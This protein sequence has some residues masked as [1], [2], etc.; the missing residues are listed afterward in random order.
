MRRA[1]PEYQGDLAGFCG[2]LRAYL[3]WSQ[4]DLGAYFKL[5]HTAITRYEREQTKPQVGYLASLIQLVWQERPR[6]STHQAELTQAYLLAQLNQAINH[7]YMEKDEP[8]FESWAELCAIGEAYR[9]KRLQKATKTP[10]VDYQHG[11]DSSTITGILRQ[12]QESVDDPQ[13]L[14]RTLLTIEQQ[15]QDSLLWMSRTQRHLLEVVPDEPILVDDLLQRIRVKI[16]SLSQIRDKELYLRLHELRY[17]GWIARQQRMGKWY[18][19]RDRTLDILSPDSSKVVG[20]RIRA[21]E[22]QT[23]KEI[24]QQV[25]GSLEDQER[26]KEKLMQIEADRRN[27]VQRLSH[28]QRAVLANVPPTPTLVDFV[29][30]TVRQTVPSLG[31]IRD[32]ELYLRLHELRYLGLIHRN[33]ADDRWYYWRERKTDDV[34]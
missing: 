4:R 20:Q 26:L 12:L 18:Y 22:V 23:I 6:T 2:I 24:L 28:T 16:S 25:Q 5:H 10:S 1:L 29:L 3:G 19:W 30:L 21:D 13:T 8:P 17:L 11:P 27:A 9:Q 34:I 32:K 15:R 33:L 14:E 31:Q 7:D